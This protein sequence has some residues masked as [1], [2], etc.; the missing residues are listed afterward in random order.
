L[1][2]LAGERFS[3]AVGLARPEVLAYGMRT[4]A[5]VDSVDTDIIPRT[6]LVHVTRLADFDLLTAII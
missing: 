2:D 4:I 1:R 6:K 3:A 5:V